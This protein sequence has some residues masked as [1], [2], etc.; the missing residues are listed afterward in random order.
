MAHIL[1]YCAYNVSHPGDGYYL[2]A[3]LDYSQGDFLNIQEPTHREGF[4]IPTIHRMLCWELLGALLCFALPFHPTHAAGAIPFAS[5]PHDASLVLRRLWVLSCLGFLI[6]LQLRRD[7][8]MDFCLPILCALSFI[9]L[10][11]C[12]LGYHLGLEGGL[13]KN[14]FH[15]RWFAVVD[16]HLGG[17]RADLLW[18]LTL[19]FQAILLR[20]SHR[21]L[22]WL[23]F[24]WLLMVTFLNP[25]LHSWVAVHLTS[26]PTYYRLLWLLPVGTGLGAFFPLSIRLLIRGIP[27]LQL[28]RALPVGIMV[29]CL[30]GSLILPRLIL[31]KTLLPASLRSFSENWEK[32]PE[33]IL[34]IGKILAGDPE[35]LH[36]RILCNE[37]VASFLTPLSRNFRFVQTRPNYTPFLLARERRSLEGTE[38]YLLASI[39]W[40]AKLPVRFLPSDWE[41]RDLLF[42]NRWWEILLG[43]KAKEKIETNTRQLLKKYKVKYFILGPTD[44]GVDVLKEEGF[45]SQATEGHYVLWRAGRKYFQ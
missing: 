8:R 43:P 22:Y 25:A 20:E 7:Q 18:L 26:Y 15:N 23:F 39:L 34:S 37:G 12:W 6:T 45:S 29:C 32:I 1:R 38:R 41:A 9:A 44:A 30:C 14:L 24:P 42:G 17:G 27:A 16:E 10:L 13:P 33:G 36:V 19:P 2:A 31:K 11:G 40:R 4:A 5:A 35:L 3:V 21:Q 28:S